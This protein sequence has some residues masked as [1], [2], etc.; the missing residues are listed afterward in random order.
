[1]KKIITLCF[2]A[3]AMVMGTQTISAQSM[4][5]VNA[6]A[7]TKTKELKQA[8]KLSNEIEDK[9]YTI[10]QEYIKTKASMDQKKA[11]GKI[12]APETEKKFS[13][14]LADKFKVIFTE[15]QMQRYLTY[16]DTHNQ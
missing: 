4:M 14:L 12:I 15:D 6:K 13:T 11:S 5:E 10:F 3:F 16:V 1:M 2:F 9:V 8:L 7:A